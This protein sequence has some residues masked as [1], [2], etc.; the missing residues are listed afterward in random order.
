MDASGN[1]TAVNAFASDGLAGRLQGGSWTYY[2]F[3]PQGSAAIRTDASGNVASSNAYTQESILGAVPAVRSPGC[4][5]TQK[6]PRRLDN[7]GE[8]G[9]RRA[10]RGPL[11]EN[12]LPTTTRSR[13][14]VSR[15]R[16]RPHAE[17]CSP[18]GGASLR[19]FSRR[20]VAGPSN[21]IPCARW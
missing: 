21:L 18:L 8:Q 19:A 9:M 10:S 12:L 3:D 11:D 13:A 7:A 6:N 5:P 4:G 15:T 1:V 17:E 2:G 20:R 16:D 14:L